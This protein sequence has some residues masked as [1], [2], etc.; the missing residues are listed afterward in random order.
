MKERLYY[1]TLLTGIILGLVA[2]K[3]E[4]GFTESEGALKLLLAFQIKCMWFQKS[5]GREQ[6]F[7]KTVRF[8]FIVER[9]WFKNTR[10]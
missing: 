2:C 5:V 4:A 6:T 8:V 7:D 9:R 10:E 1:I 3:K